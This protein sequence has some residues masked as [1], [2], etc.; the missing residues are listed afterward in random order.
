MET[1]EFETEVIEVIRRTHDIKSFR[2][3]VPQG[4]NIDFK[5]GQFFVLTIKI[6][7][8]DA[9]KHFSFSISPT[10]KGYVEFT[11]RITGSEF[12]QALD[13]LKKGDWARLKLPFGTFTFEGEYEKI[14]FL[15]GGIGITCIR[16]IC[17]FASDKRVSTDIVL[18]YSNMTDEDIVF[19]QDF[20][21]MEA[22]NSNL[23]VIHTLTS[24][25]IDKSVWKGKTGYINSA[26]VKEEIP[27]YRD[28]VFYISGPPKMVNDLKTMLIDELRVDKEKIK[29]ERFL[30]Y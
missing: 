18:I 9:T 17:K 22:K 19:R 23:T 7:G 4:I 24:P 5:P 21:Q 30:G 28:R 2:F 26:M 15:S 1:K 16:S 11:K 20:E 12:S 13:H 6:K 27:D 8:Q 3:S 10:E 25:D 14:A 29:Q